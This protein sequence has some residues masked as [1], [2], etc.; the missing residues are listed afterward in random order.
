VNGC[1]CCDYVEVVAM[2]MIVLVVVAVGG[3]CRSAVVNRCRRGRGRGGDDRGNKV[4]ADI[5]CHSRRQVDNRNYH[6]NLR[7]NLSFHSVPLTPRLETTSACT[8]CIR[9]SAPAAM[10]VMTRWPSS[11]SCDEGSL[12]CQSQ[13]R[14]WCERVS[15]VV[16][17]GRIEWV[18]V[19]VR[20]RICS[21]LRT[22]AYSP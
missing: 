1:G 14:V 2:R 17:G 9:S 22:T 15:R 8:E 3:D 13:S 11:C 16:G 20:T 21:R 18:C 5:L 10:R 6:T 12:A 19:F 4:M 7:T